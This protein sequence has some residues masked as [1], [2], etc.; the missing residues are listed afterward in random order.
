[1]ASIIKAFNK[2][3]DVIRRGRIRVIARKR[4]AIELPNNGLPFKVIL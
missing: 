4:Y 3:T 2:E 1:M